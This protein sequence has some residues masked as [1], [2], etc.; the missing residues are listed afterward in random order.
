MTD[1]LSFLSFLLFSFGCLDGYTP[2]KAFQIFFFLFYFF[3][4]GQD[5]DLQ[6]LHVM[7]WSFSQWGKVRIGSV[8]MHFDHTKPLFFNIF[9][10]SILKGTPSS[11]STSNIFHF[12]P[13]YPTPCNW[14]ELARF[15]VYDMV[16]S[17]LKIVIPLRPWL[18]ANKVSH[19]CLWHVTWKL[20]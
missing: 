5:C 6:C 18:L 17:S 1:Y 3:L 15:M 19:L 10:S 12:L 11:A 9:A 16:S 8:W 14:W 2:H 4:I 7:T 13:S 20:G